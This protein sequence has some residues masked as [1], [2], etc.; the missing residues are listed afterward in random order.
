MI[1]GSPTSPTIGSP[2]ALQASMPP[3]RLTAVA[4]LLDQELRGPTGTSAR[5][6][7]A[8]DHLVAGQ[9]FQWSGT[10]LRAMCVA[11]GA[12]P[13]SHSLSSRTSNKKAP[14]SSQL[15]RFGDVDSS[16]FDHVRSFA[17]QPVRQN[18]VLDFSR[19]SRG[20][21]LQHHDVR[22]PPTARHR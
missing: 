4:T 5:A 20:L 6:T 7:D 12:R 9:F 14:S 10:S 19:D 3:S 21:D 22:A 13:D 17:W 2:S 18:L 15:D 8:D 11:V 1:V 16:C